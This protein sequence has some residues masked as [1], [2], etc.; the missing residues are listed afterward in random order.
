MKK[1]CPRCSTSYTCREDRTDMCHCTRIFLV[2][3]VREY[4]SAEYSNCLCHKC[5]RETNMS[6]H[7]FGVNPIYKVTNNKK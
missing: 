3:E 6:F 2:N 1:I 7:S 4:L 5:L